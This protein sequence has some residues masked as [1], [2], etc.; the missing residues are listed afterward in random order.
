[1]FKIIFLIVMFALIIKIVYDALYVDENTNSVM[2][3]NKTIS[4]YSYQKYAKFY[5]TTLPIDNEFKRKIE[6]IYDLIVNKK[7]EDLREIAAKTNCT[8]EECILKIK[9]LKNKRVIGDNYYIDHITGVIK[10][11]SKED[12]ALL[13]K[14]SPYIYGKHFQVDEIAV[15]LPGTTV[16]NQK[17]V[18]KQI[19]KDLKYLDDK[20]LINGIMINDVDEKIIY[21]SIEKRLKEK[22]YVTIQC[23]HCGALN[24]I[25]RGNKKRCEYCDSIIEA[26]E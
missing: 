26:K 5:G 19:F 12:K 18:E 21:Y 8:Y 4:E 15:H 3:K 24:D 10:K 16:N 13:K 20:D 7:Y 2:K 11:C 14:Y 9:Y 17:K 22:D 6:A 23:K 1:M 25:H